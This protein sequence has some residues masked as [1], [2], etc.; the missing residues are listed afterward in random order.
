MSNTYGISNV[1]KEKVDVYNAEEVDA[2]AN[3]L[4]MYVDSQ[5]D[6]L[7]NVYP[8]IGNLGFRFVPY[9]TI[10]LTNGAYHEN[11]LLDYVFPNLPQSQ[12]GTVKGFIAFDVGINSTMALTGSVSLTYNSEGKAQLTIDINRISGAI[13]SVDLSILYVAHVK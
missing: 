8:V 5:I 1:N 13:D 3:N 12:I 6:T 2:I 11:I 10:P 7:S 4:K 9:G